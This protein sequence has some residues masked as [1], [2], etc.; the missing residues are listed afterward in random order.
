MADLTEAIITCDSNNNLWTCCV[1]D[2]HNGTSLMSYRGGGQAAP[3]T[4]NL[5][6]NDYIAVAD[7]T[8]PLLH[9][10]QL[11]SQQT[12]Q[13]LRFVLPARAA[14]LAFS[15]DG[16]YCVAGIADKLY[17][18]KTS[19]GSLLTIITRHYQAITTIKFTEDGSHF[20]SA[21]EDGMVIVWSL[22]NVCAHPEVELM[23]QSI[24]GQHDPLHVF[25]DHSLP[26]TDIFIS[27]NG[28]KG[29]LATVS[30]DHSCKIYQI[31]SGEMILNLLLDTAILSMTMDLLELNVFLGTNEGK[32]HNF[33]LT[34]P[35]INR[36]HHIGAEDHQYTF[37]GHIK[38]VTC[39][40]ASIDGERLLSGSLDGNIIIWHIASRQQIR[41]IP[42]NG[43]IL[44]GLF[45]VVPKSMFR[46]DH[47]PQLI[48]HNFQRTLEKDNDNIIEDEITTKTSK[49][50]W[51]IQSSRLNPTMSLK[52]DAEDNDLEK[53]KAEYQRLKKTNADLYTFAIEKIL[54]TNIYNTDVPQNDRDS[55]KRR[56]KSTR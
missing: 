31:S 3:R 24:A 7:K 25:F 50:F 52:P 36:D 32:I 18:W 27:K 16:R 35:P 49:K 17:I 51:N 55:R 37:K 42:H 10:W 28:V 38:A 8:K 1:W 4:L 48:L 6:G 12:V 22:A 13:G 2:P 44:N 34:N 20:V 9:V 43:A 45:T 47:V 29:R 33:N 23:T 56:K 14:A 19:S 46:H 5:V 39:L 54:E 41:I 40:S 53:L 30:I 11:N 26:V 15:K 21:G